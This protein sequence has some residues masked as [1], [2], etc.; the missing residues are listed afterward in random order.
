M[1]RS[2]KG[3][4]TPLRL[5]PCMPPLLEE[6]SI[7][8][9]SSNGDTM[10]AGKACQTLVQTYFLSNRINVSEPV[11]DPGVDI[12]VEKP[13]GWIRGQVKKVVYQNKLDYNHKKNYG[14]EI[15]RSRFNFNFQ[16]SSDGKRSQKGPKDFDYFYHVL[17]TQYRLLIWETPVDVVPVRNNGTFI[18]GKNPVIDRDSFIRRKADIDFN[19]YLIYT[20]FDPIIFQKF[21]NFFLTKEI[22]SLNKFLEGG[23]H[24]Q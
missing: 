10:Y 17:L 23:E 15:Y 12:L 3:P 14:G 11:V 13:C 24:D 9:S 6:E 20:K 8:C 16:G 18:Y 5:V 2:H 19:Q 1:K 7:N 21:P 4:G 22:N